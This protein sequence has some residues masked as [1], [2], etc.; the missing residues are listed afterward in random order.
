[1][2]NTSSGKAE[3]LLPVIVRTSLSRKTTCIWPD[4]SSATTQTLNLEEI[5]IPPLHKY[6]YE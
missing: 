6:C 1:M 5:F 4:M 2:T 3:P